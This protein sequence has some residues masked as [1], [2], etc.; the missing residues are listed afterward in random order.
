[1]QV[2]IRPFQVHPTVSINNTA[3]TASNLSTNVPTAIGNR[4][5]RITVEG[6]VSIYWAI[7]GAATV[8]GSTKMLA[9]TVET[10]FLPN[11]AVTIQ[12]IAAATGS[13]ISFTFGES[14]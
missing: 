1:M 5:V 4:T 14:A 6:T 13:T 9:N 7:N 11:D 8:A 2:S 3:V 10:F 12:Y